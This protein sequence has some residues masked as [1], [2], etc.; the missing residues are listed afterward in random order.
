[1]LKMQ[2]SVYCIQ[3]NI[4]IPMLYRNGTFNEF[5]FN[6]F[7]EIA[8]M[9]FTETQSLTPEGIMRMRIGSNSKTADVEFYRHAI[10]FDCFCVCMCVCTGL[11]PWLHCAQQAGHRIRAFGEIFSAAF[12][13][14]KDL[15]SDSPRMESF[16]AS[17]VIR[18]LLFNNGPTW[19][20]VDFV[21]VH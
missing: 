5:E 10:T 13:L 20:L 16:K 21:K 12:G 6:I 3:H 7:I 11:F 8:C 17:A 4:P 15:C 9:H 18:S 1:M 2:V 14:V 19:T